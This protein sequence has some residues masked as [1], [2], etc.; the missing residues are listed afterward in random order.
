MGRW[1]GRLE[2]V[3]YYTLYYCLTLL[4]CNVAG[5]LYTQN[6][7]VYVDMFA[8]HVGHPFQHLYY[9]PTLT[10]KMVPI[11]GQASSFLVFLE[12]SKT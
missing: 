8:L 2:H 7:L 5:S 11:T 4:A 3:T 10:R 1:N 12:F 9:I 6:V